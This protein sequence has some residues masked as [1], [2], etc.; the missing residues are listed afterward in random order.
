MNFHPDIRIQVIDLLGGRVEG[1]YG[2]AAS[3]IAVHDYIGHMASSQ[4]LYLIQERERKQEDIEAKL[5]ELI[6]AATA[7]PSLFSN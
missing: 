6:D 4:A 7:V 3:E 2:D 1:K 5:K